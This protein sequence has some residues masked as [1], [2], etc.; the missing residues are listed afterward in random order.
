[1]APHDQLAT[2]HDSDPAAFEWSSLFGLHPKSHPD[3]QTPAELALLSPALPLD[4]SSWARGG[5]FDITSNSA[6]PVWSRHGGRQESAALHFN[7]QCDQGNEGRAASHQ[8]NQQHMQGT[9][10]I[11]LRQP[12]DH[13]HYWSNTPK[14]FHTT[15]CLMPAS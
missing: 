13:A 7:A 6:R 2:L 3:R 12:D 5:N 4:A 9:G 15:S 8:P 14:P 10:S 11:E 1:M